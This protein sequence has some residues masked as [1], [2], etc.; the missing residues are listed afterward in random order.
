MKVNYKIAATLLLT[1][2]FTIFLKFCLNPP[3]VNTELRN[4]FWLNKTYGSERFNVVVGGDSR[5]YR[6]FSIADM[7]A[8]LPADMN[9]YNLGFSSAGYSATYINLL[10]NRLK[11]MG[12][13][14]LVL[15]LTPH[16]FTAEAVTDEMLNHYKA[17]SGFDRYKSLYLSQ[18]LKHFAP[19]KISD[20]KTAWVGN[21][22]GVLVEHFYAN[23][24]VA[25]DR[26]PASDSVALEIYTKLFGKVNVNDS[27]IDQFIFTVD[28]LH[29]TG[30]SIIAFRPPTNDAMIAIED[31]LGGFDEMDILNRLKAVGVT[32]MNF[33]NKEFNLY[34]GSHLTE[35]SARLL[36][37]KVGQEIQRILAQ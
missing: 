14:V 5:I 19:Y 15:G 37:K 16:A 27:I 3:L 11:V 26:N 10:V 9:G 28:S 31:S 21:Y 36:G 2:L 35:T 22:E 33:D 4:D 13:R 30:I 12:P 17:I 6:G 23:G 24:W 25:S 34:D 7:E 8:E 18:Y 20:L 32:W 1:T 29:K